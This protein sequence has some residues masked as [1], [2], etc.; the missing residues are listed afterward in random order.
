M[1]LRHHKLHEPPSLERNSRC[2]TAPLVRPRSLPYHPT[3]AG[4]TASPISVSWSHRR[5]RSLFD[6]RLHGAFRMHR[7][8]RGVLLQHLSVESEFLFLT[9]AIWVGSRQ[10]SGIFGQA[11]NEHEP[12]FRS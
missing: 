12:P 11:L 10:S 9:A 3:I 4:G 5:W 8:G 7:H 1:A 2:R 6:R